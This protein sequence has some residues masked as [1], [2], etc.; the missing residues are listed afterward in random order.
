MKSYEVVVIRKER[1]TYVV[2]ASSAPDAEVIAESA[3]LQSQPP[4]VR[5]V[6]DSFVHLVREVPVVS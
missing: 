3:S 6:E 2:R 5:V 1:L 4:D